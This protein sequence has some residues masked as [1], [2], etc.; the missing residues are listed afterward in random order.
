MK[1]QES[2][3]PYN[4]LG[5]DLKC[6]ERMLLAILNTDPS[7]RDHTC[8]NSYLSNIL[9]SLRQVKNVVDMDSIV[10]SIESIQRR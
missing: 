9:Q 3:V 10:R 5:H 4:A 8:N 7:E 2:H 6:L 1:N